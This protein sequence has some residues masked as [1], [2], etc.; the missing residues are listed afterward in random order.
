ML[1]IFS[2]RQANSAL[3]AG[4]TKRVSERRTNEC[5]P[6]VRHCRPFIAASAGRT[7]G[8]T[9]DFGDKTMDTAGVK[10]LGPAIKPITSRRSIRTISR[11]DDSRA[12]MAN[13]RSLCKYA[14]FVLYCRLLTLL[15]ALQ[16]HTLILLF[17]FHPLNSL[18]FFIADCSRRTSSVLR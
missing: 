18:M 10:S 7:D 14:R 17:F 13:P 2:S 5:R 4:A 1:W 9:D 8:R 6:L 3:V 12:A 11:L 16:F 15:F